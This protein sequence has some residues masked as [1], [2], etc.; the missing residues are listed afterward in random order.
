MSSTSIYIYIYNAESDTCTCTSFVAVHLSLQQM[1]TKTSQKYKKNKK[2]PW[3]TKE[4]LLRVVT[5][6]SRQKL[7]SV[8]KASTEVMLYFQKPSR[9]MTYMKEKVLLTE[10]TVLAL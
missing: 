5:V 4:D 3:K 8:Y 1:N 6:A 2:T 10:T 9:G 7:I